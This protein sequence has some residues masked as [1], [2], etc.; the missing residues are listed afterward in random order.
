MLG[1]VSLLSDAPSKMGVWGSSFWSKPIYD[2]ITACTM[3]RGGCHLQKTT[4]WLIL[5]TLKFIERDGRDVGPDP[6]AMPPVS[7]SGSFLR[8]R[9]PISIPKD[10]NFFGRTGGK[11]IVL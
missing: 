1:K 8:C 10:P 3:H 4:A 11:R 7:C 5:P 9:V 6:F 2:C